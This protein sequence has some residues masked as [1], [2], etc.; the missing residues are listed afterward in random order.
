MKI[1][2][3]Q[4][5]LKKL[6]TTATANPCAPESTFYSLLGNRLRMA[7]M[8][9][10]MSL[11]DA[12]IHAEATRQAISLWERGERPIPSYHLWKLVRAFHVDPCDIFG[13]I[14]FCEKGVSA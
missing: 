6:K 10:Q 13:E 1:P 11:R 5:A 7:R 4:S 14:P 8:K 9:R 2:P 12:A 3:S